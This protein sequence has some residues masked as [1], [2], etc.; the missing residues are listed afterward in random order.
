MGYDEVQTK[1]LEKVL[2][3]LNNDVNQQKAFE[4]RKTLTRK[5]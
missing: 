2:P 5:I 1:P 3:W 4:G